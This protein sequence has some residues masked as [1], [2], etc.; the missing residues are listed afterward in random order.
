V[1]L[2]TKESDHEQGKQSSKKRSQKAKAGQERGQEVKT[3]EIRML[4]A[5]SAMRRGMTDYE[6]VVETHKFPEWSKNQ[7]P[8]EQK[9]YYFP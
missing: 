5:V 6:I 8:G 3:V 4:R 7:P 1:G 9:G 2:N